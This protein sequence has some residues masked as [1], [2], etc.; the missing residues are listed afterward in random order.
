MLRFILCGKVHR[1]E[2]AVCLIRLE[3]WIRLIGVKEGGVALRHGL[4]SSPAAK[5]LN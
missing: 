2:I 5:V 3:N 4:E 1:V